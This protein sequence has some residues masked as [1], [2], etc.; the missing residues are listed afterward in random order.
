MVLLIP[1]LCV[2][3]R[4]RIYGS[5]GRGYESIVLTKVKINLLIRSGRKTV[6]FKKT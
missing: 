4:F 2:K 1:V 5:D 3:G 6:K